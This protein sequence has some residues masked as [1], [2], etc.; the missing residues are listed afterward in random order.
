MVMI[1]ECILIPPGSPSGLTFGAPEPPGGWETGGVSF[2]EGGEMASTGLKSA[3]RKDRDPRSI[4]GTSMC[5]RP[6]SGGIGLWI[7][8]KRVRLPS[9]TL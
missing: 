5:T 9:C 2:Y 8:S 7:R 1:C 3:R 4:R 6:K